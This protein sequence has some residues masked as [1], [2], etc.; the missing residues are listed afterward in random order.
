MT[1]WLEILDATTCRLCSGS[2]R[3]GNDMRQSEWVTR[4]ARM[5][6]TEPVPTGSST[7]TRV[8]VAA[9]R[10]AQ[11]RPG[12]GPRR[13]ASLAV[14]ATLSPTPGRDQFSPT[15]W[16][17]VCACRRSRATSAPS[18]T[19]ARKSLT[20]PTPRSW[21][22][23]GSKALRQ[24]WSRCAADIKSRCAFL[25][26]LGGASLEGGGDG[27]APGT[28]VVEHQARLDDALRP[29]RFQE[30]F[31]DYVVSNEELETGLADGTLPR[32]PRT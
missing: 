2:A 4:M 22:K 32:H 12:A 28:T 19:R 13:S 20:V 21:S 11:G 29:S 24:A 10:D 25:G 26:E 7:R 5:A 23:P 14:L 9:R 18:I 31:D 30:L 8:L 3:G 1:G 15:G 6:A 27:S 17:Y 16:S